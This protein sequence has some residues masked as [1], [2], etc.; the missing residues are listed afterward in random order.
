L[1]HVGIVA[2]LAGLAAALAPRDGV[3]GQQALRWVAVCVAFAAAGGE[4]ILVVKTVVGRWEEL[5]GLLQGYARRI[6]RHRGE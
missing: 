4:M 1:Y 6:R 5:A 2:L 3:G